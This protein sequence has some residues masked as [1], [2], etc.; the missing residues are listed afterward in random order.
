MRTKLFS[1][2]FF[3]CLFYSI[4]AQL[5]ADIP[6]K[7]LKGFWPFSGNANDESGNGHHGTVHNARL[8]ADRFGNKNNAYS[9]DGHTSFI[10][11]LYEGIL[12]ANPRAVS[13]WALAHVNFRESHGMEVVSWGDIQHYP[14]AGQRFG[15]SFGGCFTCEQKTE[16]LGATVDAA[17]AGVTFEGHESVVDGNW[18][19][20]IFQFKGRYV[21]DVEVYQDGL[22]LTHEPFRFYKNCLI[23][24]KPLMP[25]TFGVLT[26]PTMQSYFSGMLDDVAIYD[27]ALSVEEIEALYQAPDPNKKFTVKKWVLPALITLAVLAGLVW[28]IVRIALRREKQKNQLKNNWYE[29]ENKVLKAQMDPHFV[30]NSLNTIQQFIIVNEN[31]KAQ[32]YLSKFS[33]LIRKMLES[34]INDSITLKEEIDLCERYLEIES[35]RF[36]AV[37]NYNIEI[38]RNADPASIHIPNFLIQPFIENAIWHGLLPK[39][40]GEMLLHI[41]FEVINKNTLLCVVDD[42]GVGR[43]QAQPKQVFE[44]KKSLAITF[45]RQRLQLMSKMKKESYGVAITDKRHSNGSP[46]GTLIHITLPILT[47]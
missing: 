3:L 13:F 23:N 31:E 47:P 22:L 19:H 7:G 5:P 39:E 4:Q 24:T 14:H 36:N 17:D 45:I 35:L 10:S 26:K 21:K 28:L 40:E 6:T 25:V 38:K 2:A 37:F 32:L 33:R 44:R 11:T 9:F 18:H 30:F 42:N 27:R 41:S 16:H 29:Q 43:Q 46:L 1:V 15:C 8:A 12:G 20:Y 34:N